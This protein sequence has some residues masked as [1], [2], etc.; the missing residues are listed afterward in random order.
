MKKQALRVAWFIVVMAA[1]L[2]AV[3]FLNWVPGALEPG[4]MK[5]YP[6]VDAAAKSLPRY[7]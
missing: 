5:R 1:V 7:P 2:G 4:L 6:T 3:A